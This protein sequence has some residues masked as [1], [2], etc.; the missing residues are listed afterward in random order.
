MWEIAFS[1]CGSSPCYVS[2]S[3]R[4][5]RTEEAEHTEDHRVQFFKASKKDASKKQ[6]S[7]TSH[8]RLKRPF[9]F[10][11]NSFSSKKEASKMSLV[12]PRSKKF[13][14]QSR[15]MSLSARSPPKILWRVRRFLRKPCFHF[16]FLVKGGVQYGSNCLE[17]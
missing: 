16:C 11:L 1:G 7:S 6:E 4:T 17:F 2:T 15:G 8:A 5:G 13:P 14:S 3:Q 9:L 12:N 10:V